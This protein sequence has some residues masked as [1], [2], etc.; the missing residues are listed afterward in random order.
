MNA[1]AKA[2]RVARMQTDTNPS[3]A[4]KAAA[5]YAKGKLPWRGLEIAI[6]NPKGSMRSGKDKN[7]KPWKCRLP[8]DYG[9]FLKSEGAD[10]DHVDVYMGPKHA[11]D[12]VFIVDQVNTET[13]K[14]DEHKVLVGYMDKAAALADYEAAFSDGKAKDRIGAVSEL[15]LPEFKA[16]LKGDTKKPLALK[17]FAAGGTAGPPSLPGSAV[18][19]PDNPSGEPLS[20]L[21][22]QLRDMHSGRGSRQAVFVPAPSVQSFLGSKHPIMTGG[23]PIAN[24]DGKGGM[25]ICRDKTTANQALVQRDM[26]TPMQAVIG[27]LTGAGL[28]KPLDGTTAVQQVTPEGAVTRETLARPQDVPAATQDLT[29]P[30]RH[31]RA[32]PAEASIARRAEGVAQDE[33]QGYAGGGATSWRSANAPY[34]LQQLADHLGVSVDDLIANPQVIAASVAHM[35]DPRGANHVA[36]SFMDMVDRNGGGQQGILKTV[37]GYDTMTMANGRHIGSLAN[38]DQNATINGLNVMSIQPTLEHLRGVMSGETPRILPEGYTQNF[39]PAAA[40]VQPIR[41]G[42]WNYYKA[43]DGKSVYAPT[44]AAPAI[45][46]GQYVTT[47]SGEYMVPDASQKPFQ[48]SWSKPGSAE[49]SR[50]QAPVTPAQTAPNV[51]DTLPPPMAAGAPPPQPP[52]PENNAPPVPATPQSQTASSSP[53]SS[54]TGVKSVNWVEGPLGLMPQWDDGSTALQPIGAP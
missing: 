15:S 9:Y 38:G 46:G 5:N 8:T 52:A 26:G 13:G 53:P 12:K 14:F 39:S 21:V 42:S 18:L 49:T 51:Q 32:I 30:D 25:L 40:R 33:A 47:P 35:E 22:A 4:Q 19:A 50:P 16:W 17:R 44:W 28:G 24:F 37:A 3:D 20:D 6:E 10:G 43:P 31:V 7:G 2:L 27:Y 11:S 23:V 1:I 41:P 36:E 45:Q 54:S 29:E 34:G 48:V